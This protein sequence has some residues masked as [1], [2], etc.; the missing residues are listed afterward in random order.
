MNPDEFIGRL[1]GLDRSALR[2]PADATRVAMPDEAD[3]VLRRR[4]VYSTPA[5]VPDS[6]V[7]EAKR[8]LERE[9]GYRDRAYR[10]TGGVPTIGYGRTG[11]D[12]RP[13]MRTTRAAEEPWLEDRIRR[14]AAWLSGKR[15]VEPHAELISAVYNLGRTGYLRTGAEGALKQ[16]NLDAAGDSLV[17]NGS[18]AR[19]GKGRRAP[20]LKPRREREAEGLRA[21]GDGI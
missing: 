12:V 19:V 18:L 8:I 15:G 2:A 13:G 9:E 16:G 10:D 6:I 21:R 4:A 17:R 14:E 20:I 1:L 11:P 5:A 3:V 7:S